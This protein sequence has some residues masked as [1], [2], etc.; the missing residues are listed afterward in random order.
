MKTIAQSKFEEVLAKAKNGTITVND[1]MAVYQYASKL[2]DKQLDW[3]ADMWKCLKEG[4]SYEFSKKSEDILDSGV[5][6]N[7]CFGSGR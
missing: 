6:Y 7:N 2:S 3:I 4:K 1:C 5:V